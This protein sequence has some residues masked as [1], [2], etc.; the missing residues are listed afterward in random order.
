MSSARDK[1]GE[2]DRRNFFKKAAAIGLGGYGEWH[3]FVAVS[4]GLG[5]GH[6]APGAGAP[7][8]FRPVRR[9]GLLT[10]T[11]RNVRHSKQP[12]DAR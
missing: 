5:R 11:G 7:Q 9:N 8:A 4:K 12:F 1:S 10:F 2:L 6:P 3:L